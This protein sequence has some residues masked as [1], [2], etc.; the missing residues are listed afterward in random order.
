MVLCNEDIG[1]RMKRIF[2][3]ALLF[4]AVCGFSQDLYY[5]DALNMH[6]TSYVIVQEY[7]TEEQL[8]IR[9]NYDIAHALATIQLYEG[10]WTE[11]QEQ[12]YAIC[13]YRI[14]AKM[15]V[16]PEWFKEIEKWKD[17][18]RKRIESERG[19]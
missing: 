4:V 10:P 7:E 1:G 3:I 13:I 15:R 18:I 9:W 14:T 17:I 19:R 8:H 6:T 11:Q 16:R 12:K 2:V 5:L